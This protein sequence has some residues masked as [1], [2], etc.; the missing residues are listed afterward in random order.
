MVVEMTVK[1]EPSPDVS[2]NISEPTESGP[3]DQKQL[4]QYVDEDVPDLE[5]KEMPVEVDSNEI[6]TR[7]VSIKDNSQSD[8]IGS[9]SPLSPL[10]DPQSPRS[11]SNSYSRKQ[12]TDAEAE[13]SLVDTWAMDQD[14]LERNV[15]QQ[16]NEAMLDRENALDE[17]RLEKT[18]NNKRH[19]QD[20]IR[21]LQQKLES[22]NVRISEKQKI[23]E[24][25]E[26]IKK[27]D[28]KALDE[29]IKDIEGR[30]RDRGVG[31]NQYSNREFGK[32]Q[33]SV[34]Q[35]PAK[36]I[37]KLPDE[38]QHDYLVRTGK[39]TPFS[40]TFMAN[41][42][43]KNV[44]NSDSKPE[45]SHQQ[46]RLPGMELADLS[47]EDDSEIEPDETQDESESVSTLRKRRKITNEEEY[48]ISGDESEDEDIESD[49][50]D[51]EFLLSDVEVTSNKRKRSNAKDLK[52]AKKKEKEENDLNLIKG[53]DDGDER[54]YRVRLQNWLKKRRLYREK[55]NKKK[56]IQTD[57][58]DEREE[59]QKPHP[60]YKE[61]QLDEKFKVPGDIYTSLFDYQK[62]GVQWQWELYTQ[63][64][65]GILSDEMGLGK[66]VQVVA[67]IAGLM[68]SGLLDKPALIVCPATV[69]KQWVNEFHRWWPA[70]R[71]G[72]LHSIG[73][74]MDLKNEEKLEES[75]E[76]SENG[77]LSLATVK[78]M[79][80]ANALIN[81]IMGT[82]MLITTDFFILLLTI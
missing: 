53:L 4:L 62:T 75:L 41:P 80:G 55:I 82:G 18:I 59:W 56:G 69:M 61:F 29:D 68:Y 43:L 31:Q 7:N 8:S 64:V 54:V 6:N 66:T 16:A 65:G 10:S 23:S 71:V 5:V 25:I 70:L 14:Q 24:E 35:Q 32:I 47:D 76:T 52:K 20:K 9:D 27:V 28:I 67:F 11:D 3:S 12:E 21:R 30:I 58:K 72:I 34:G 15:V 38:S 42:S 51:E 36:D 57:K 37:G 2:Q 26:K 78:R 48:H 73:S 13:L 39:I 49:A 19:H 74:G 81:D 22:R 63:N 46:L 79:N 45:M 44:I 40:D 50:E 1:K 77:N 33:D 17:K 60:I